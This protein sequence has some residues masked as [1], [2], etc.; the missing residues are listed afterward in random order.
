MTTKPTRGAVVG[1]DGSERSLAAVRWAL[2]HVGPDDPITL[3][4][5]LGH[6]ASPLPGGLVHLWPGEIVRSAEAIA[7]AWAR[8]GDAL[9]SEVE[10]VIQRGA[11]ADLLA[12]VA[13]ERDAEV[14]VVGKERRWL[15]LLRASVARDLLKRARRAVVVVR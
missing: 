6:E 14:I 8:D 2:E 1:Y 10:L 9:E 3:V 7:R 4:A 11:P 15:G 5:A 13:E 12:R